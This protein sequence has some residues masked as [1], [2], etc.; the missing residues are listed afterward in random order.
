MGAEG[1]EVKTG[2]FTGRSP[3]DKF[4]IKDAITK[5]TVYWND[6]TLPMDEKYFH[7]IQQKIKTWLAVKDDLWVRDCYACADER[8]RI[9]IRVVTEKPWMNLFAYNMFLRPQE[10]ELED[11]RPDWQILSAPAVAPA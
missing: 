2:E 9:N 3:K 8:Y 4:I 7:I 1:K 11:F 6:F 5:D 10:E